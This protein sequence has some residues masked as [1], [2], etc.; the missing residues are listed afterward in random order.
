MGYMAFR[1]LSNEEI[2]KN[3]NK[4]FIGKLFCYFSAFFVFIAWFLGVYLIVKYTDNVI[5]YG[6]VDV[7]LLWSLFSGLFLA[8]SLGAAFA[9][10]SI[11]EELYEYKKEVASIRE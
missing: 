10:S 11:K 2:Q 5:L 4:F 8:A 7:A 9:F 3:I 1:H 6:K